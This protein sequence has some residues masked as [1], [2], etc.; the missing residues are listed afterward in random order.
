MPSTGRSSELSNE[1]FKH[2]YGVSRQDAQRAAAVSR[3]SEAY[4]QTR[5]KLETERQQRNVARNA[6]EEARLERQREARVRS[7]SGSTKP[8]QQTQ[9]NPTATT[10]TT[11]PKVN[12]TGANLTQNTSTPAKTPPEKEEKSVTTR[13]AESVTPTVQ[14]AHTDVSTP[15]TADAEFSTRR[16]SSPSKQ[17]IVQGLVSAAGSVHRVGS[18]VNRAVR[19]TIS[20]IKR[21]FKESKNTGMRLTEIQKLGY[22]RAEAKEILAA[23]EKQQAKTRGSKKDTSTEREQQSS[24]KASI[25]Q[26]SK[27]LQARTIQRLKDNKDKR[28]QEEWNKDYTEELRFPHPGS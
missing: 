19:G 6:R 1:G 10:T 12:N 22:T 18:N 25:N 28:L 27:D 8:T 11:K 26:S 23:E 15:P 17:E 3:S 2:L 13:D 4:A 21:I 20:D 5:D 24:R 7:T 9:S 16:L 14:R